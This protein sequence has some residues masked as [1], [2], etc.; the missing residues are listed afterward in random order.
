MLGRFRHR[1][2]FLS[3]RG[4]VDHHPPFCN[5]FHDHKVVH[6]PVHDG[7]QLQ[8]PQVRKLETNGP[9]GKM[10]LVRDLHQATQ[11]HSFQ[12]HGMATPQRVQVDAVAVVR[13]D[14]CEA[15][16][17]TFSRFGLIDDRQAAPAAEIQQARQAHILTLSKGSRNQLISE[18]F[19]SRMSARSSMS[20][21]SG[22]RFP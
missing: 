8:L 9:T 7:R 16:E 2:K 12:R 13:S 22:I 21:W 5:G 14:H 11:G 19:S 17:T 20:A 3:G 6:V 18:R 1:Q 4:I 10:H 15:G